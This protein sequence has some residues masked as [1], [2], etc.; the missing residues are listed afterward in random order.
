MKKLILFLTLTTTISFAQEKN[1]QNIP[2]IQ[3]T[4]TFTQEVTPDKIILSIT[5]SES[6]TNGKVSMNELEK[7]LKDVLLSNNI[8]LAKQL[9]LTDLSSNFKDYFIKKT[10]IHKVKNYEL[11]VHNAVTASK[12]LKG[13]EE[14]NISNV[15]LIKT[16]YSKIEELKIE[17]KGKAVL[18][19]KRQAQE[20]VSQLNQKLGPAIYIS[21]M[22]TYYPENH[23]KI[24][25]AANAIS[26]NESSDEL[27]IDFNKIS[28]SATLTVYFKLEE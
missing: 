27:E 3:T 16:E 25:F 24:M 28:I 22:Q 23:R 13:L 9:T 8:D 7:K 1:Y 11:T 19:A 14:E 20:I 17:L 6:N 10:D 15:Q 18:K 21:D 5:L 26:K 12:V 4:A 2:Q